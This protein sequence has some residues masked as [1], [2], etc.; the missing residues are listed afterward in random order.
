MQSR[1]FVFAGCALLAGIATTAQAQRPFTLGLAVGPSL[2]ASDFNET[3]KIG[4]NVAGH[5]GV[6][7]PASAWGFRFEGFYNLFDNTDF[8]A[9]NSDMIPAIVNR[10]VRIVGGDANLV[11]DFSPAMGAGPYV[12]GGVGAYNVEPEG[13][14][15]STDLGLNAGVGARFR[16]AAVGA[17]IE[18]RFHATRGDLKLQYIPVTFGIEF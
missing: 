5:V 9:P 17:F 15:G 3:H 13:S 7:V 18:T 14:D 12:M 8:V 2:P 6:R 11:Y 10:P 16:M 1:V 4:I